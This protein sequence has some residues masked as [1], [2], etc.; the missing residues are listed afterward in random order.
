M[1]AIVRSKSRSKPIFLH[2]GVGR[3]PDFSLLKK[4]SAAMNAFI[5]SDF[6]IYLIIDTWILII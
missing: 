2:S 4:W 6:L 1:S 5:W 3:N